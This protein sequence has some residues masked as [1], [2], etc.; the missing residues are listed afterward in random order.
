MKADAFITTRS[1]AFVSCGSIVFI[2]LVFLGVFRFS[3]WI[4]E[5]G[6]TIQAELAGA[7]LNDVE[8]KAVQFSALLSKQWI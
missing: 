4:L 5:I 8:V 3:F 1:H 2:I 6:T 7:D